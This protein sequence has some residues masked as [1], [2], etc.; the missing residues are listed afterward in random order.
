MRGPKR[1]DAVQ[2][3]GN[4]K[5]RSSLRPRPPTI[6]TPP[7]TA[8]ASDGTGWLRHDLCTYA[9]AREW[10][11]P[12]IRA[13]NLTNQ[14]PTMG[15][16]RTANA[17]LEIKQNQLNICNLWLGR[18]QLS[19]RI[20]PTASL[21]FRTTRRKAFSPGL[22][23]AHQLDELR[24]RAALDSTSCVR[25]LLRAP[26]IHR[27]HPSRPGMEPYLVVHRSLLVCWMSTRVC[28]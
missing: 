4:S 18:T 9:F 1:S 19:F 11:L 15:C 25:F 27:S 7:T 6:F 3:C 12:T 26:S 22:S 16:A 8:D 21:T 5:R 28:S 17:A 20:C 10:R 2:E 13:G 23:A 14:R 24:P